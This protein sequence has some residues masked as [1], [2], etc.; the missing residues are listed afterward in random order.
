VTNITWDVLAIGSDK[1]GTGTFSLNQNNRRKQKQ[2]EHLQRSVGTHVP[3][4]NRKVVGSIP[5]VI[6]F[7]N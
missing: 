6:G 4:N 1:R 5:D 2:K 7:F 3:Q